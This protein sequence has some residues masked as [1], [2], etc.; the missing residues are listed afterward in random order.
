[1]AAALTRARP[2]WDSDAM[3]ATVNIIGK[4]ITCR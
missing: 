1:M 4:R 3:R 2:A